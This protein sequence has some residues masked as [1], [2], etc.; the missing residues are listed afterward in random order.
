VSVRLGGWLAGVCCVGSC[1]A[2]WNP[3]SRLLNCRR[4]KAILFAVHRGKRLLIHG[5][6]IVA[7]GGD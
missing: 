2:K 3:L 6:A 1:L 4:D 5:Q 7:K